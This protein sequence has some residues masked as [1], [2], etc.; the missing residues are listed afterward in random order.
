M[1]VKKKRIISLR[2][3][4]RVLRSFNRFKS[5]KDVA[6]DTFDRVE[7]AIDDRCKINLFIR[8]RPQPMVLLFTDTIARERFYTQVNYIQQAMAAEIL[9]KK[10][11]KTAA[12]TA[13]TSSTTSTSSS[14]SSSST[15]VNIGESSVSMFVGSWNLGNAPFTYEG[16][17]LFITPLKYDIYAIGLQEC[18][19]GSRDQWLHEIK[20]L[21]CQQWG[22]KSS[23][24]ASSASSSS[25]D[26]SYSSFDSDETFVTLGIVKLWEIVLM[27]L[28]RRELAHNVSNVEMGSIATGVGDVLGNK[29]GVA[30]SM[31]YGE[32]SLCFVSSHLAAR[33]ERVQ[34]RAENVIKIVKQ[35]RLARKEIDIL[36]QFDHLFWF[37]DLN[38]VTTH[39][40]DK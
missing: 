13:T 9:N 22:N 29:G 18:S 38:Y 39:T 4:E 21:I 10:N 5:Y 8:K 40:H 1:G 15:S 12:A 6:L 23:T 37:G 20:C 16:L 11:E 28:I 36:S 26:T 30:L 35:L 19:K 7:R 31:N 27:V 32:S 24:A 33:A 14:S 25:H 2:N 17:D 3:N 34:Q